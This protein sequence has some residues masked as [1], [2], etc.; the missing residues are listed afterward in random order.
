LIGVSLGK[1]YG[2][3]FYF[4][5]KTFAI[6]QFKVK[7]QPVSKSSKK[8]I[9]PKLRGRLRFPKSISLNFHSSVFGGELT[10]FW[11]CTSFKPIENLFIKLKNF[12]NYDV[13]FNAHAFFHFR[14]KH[15]FL[16]PYRRKCQYRQKNFWKISAILASP[17][18]Y[19]LF[20]SDYCTF[21]WQT[22]NSDRSVKIQI[23]CLALK[24]SSFLLFKLTKMRRLVERFYKNC[25]VRDDDLFIATRC[26]PSLSSF[27][28]REWA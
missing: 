12:S 11:Y 23:W 19:F 18:L 16:S 10:T 20:D 17:V 13:I 4:V 28:K 2:R 14:T 5:E 24:N 22:I 15:L 26:F 25:G 6:S 7:L 3:I 1:V 9:S 27:P 8:P 21:F